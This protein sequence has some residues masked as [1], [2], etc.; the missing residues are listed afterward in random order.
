M[1]GGLQQEKPGRPWGK[2]AAESSMN[3]QTEERTEGAALCWWGPGV[4]CEPCHSPASG[5]YLQS[6]E[7]PLPHVYMGTMK[8][9]G[10]GHLCRVIGGLHVPRAA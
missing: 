5:K 2:P 7:P 8:Q 1:K 9:R 4:Q 6:C 3:R 10:L